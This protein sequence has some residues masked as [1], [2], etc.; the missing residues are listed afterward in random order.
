MAM[1]IPQEP[2]DRP[3]LGQYWL[4]RKGIYTTAVPVLQRHPMAELQYRYDQAARGQRHGVFAPH[5]SN[6]CTSCSVKDYCPTQA[7]RT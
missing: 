7:G 2:A 5:V 4:A 1:G 6:F 3:I